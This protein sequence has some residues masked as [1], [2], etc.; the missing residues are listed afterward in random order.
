LDAEAARGNTVREI[1]AWPPKCELLIYLARKFAR[2]YLLEENVVFQQVNDRHYWY[3]EYS[4]NQG[5]Q[6]LVCGFAD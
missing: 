4:F 6:V 3:A 2:P 1:S 5:Q